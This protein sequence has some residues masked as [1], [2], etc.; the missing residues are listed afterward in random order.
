MKTF[1][2]GARE[3][4]WA[5]LLTYWGLRVGLALVLLVI[6]LWVVRALANLASR[7]LKRFNVEPILRRFLRNVVYAIGV[8]L[9][10]VTALDAL[11]VPP[12]SLLAVVGAAGLAIGLAMKDSLSNIASGFMLIGLR[13]FRAGDIVDIA[14]KTGVVEQVR[15]FQTLI[16]TFDNHEVTLPNSQITGGPIINF[17]ARSR[18]RCRGGHRLR[19]RNRHCARRTAQDRRF[20]REGAGRSG[21]GCHRQRT[22]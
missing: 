7:A 12:T 18:R 9:V 4:A 21:T 2:E 13:P 22:W 3:I 10:L 1:I 8:V 17:T 14:G 20:A 6:G 16:R 15:L 19:R 11:G 5:E